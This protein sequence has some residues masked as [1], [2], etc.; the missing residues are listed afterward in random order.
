[1]DRIF[2]DLGLHLNEKGTR[3]WQATIKAARMAQAVRY[4]TTNDTDSA[5]QREGGEE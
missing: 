5:H 4:E 2:I 1:M 3:I